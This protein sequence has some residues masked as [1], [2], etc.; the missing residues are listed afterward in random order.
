WLKDK[1]N[2]ARH[3]TVVQWG[4]YEGKRLVQAAADVQSGKALV[5]FG[6][7][8][9]DTYKGNGGGLHGAAMTASTVAYGMTRAFFGCG[10]AISAAHAAATSSQC[11]QAAGMLLSP[12]ASRLW[13]AGDCLNAAAEDAGGL[14]YRTGA[15]TDNALTDA[16]GVSFRDSV[17]SSA[18]RVQVF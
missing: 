2:D 1:Y 13:A 16:S 3:S 10:E 4:L 15:R 6:V 11:A 9:W 8:V 12:A 14:I 18:D 7:G 17:S 5:T